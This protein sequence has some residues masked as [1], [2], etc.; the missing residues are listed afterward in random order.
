M[1]LRRFN[2]LSINERCKAVANSEFHEDELRDGYFLFD[3]NAE[4]IVSPQGL[5][6]YKD[7]TY[8]YK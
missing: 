2:D 1:K 3:E 5:T 7:S 6:V 8:Y 4:L